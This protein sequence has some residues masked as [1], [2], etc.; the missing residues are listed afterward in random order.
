MP[1]KGRVLLDG[2]GGTHVFEEELS[3]PT[4]TDVAATRCCRPVM[5]Y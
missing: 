3:D 5:I 4:P 1:G 2:G